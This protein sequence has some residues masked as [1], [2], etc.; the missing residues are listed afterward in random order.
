MLAVTVEQWHF[1]GGD[2]SVAVESAPER[3]CAEIVQYAEKNITGM[4]K[5]IKLS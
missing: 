5:I 1:N 4:E 2:F 3:D